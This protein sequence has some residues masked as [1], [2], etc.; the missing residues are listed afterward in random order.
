MHPN[1][2][3]IG[4]DD[5]KEEWVRQILS[6]GNGR[7]EYEW[8]GRQKVA[9][10]RSIPE[11]GWILVLAQEREGSSPPHY[12]HAVQQ[13]YSG[14]CFNPYCRADYLHFCAEIS[15]LLLKAEPI[16]LPL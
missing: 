1:K 15:V 6:K 16:S 8:D 10:F 4:D 3:Y 7:Q 13:Y 12:F 2:S 11:M 5:S 14:N 9:Y